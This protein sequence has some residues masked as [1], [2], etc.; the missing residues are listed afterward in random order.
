MTHKLIAFAFGAAL[1]ASAAPHAAAQASL[2]AIGNTFDF[3]YGVSRDASTVVGLNLGTNAGFKWDAVNGYVAIGGAPIQIRVDGDGSRI[4]GSATFSGFSTAAYWSGGAWTSIGGLGGSSGTDVSS[5]WGISD[6]GQTIVGLGWIN[7][8]SA[9]AF[10]WTQAGGIVDLGSSGASSRANAVSG[11]GVVVGG[12]DDN[13]TNGTRRPAYW[14][15]PGAPVL[16][17]QSPGAV[18]GA[19][20]D[21]KVLAGSLS[22]KVMR[23]T[24]QNGPYSLGALAAG[25]Q[26]SAADVDDQGTTLVGYSGPF[27][28]I[29]VRRAFIWRPGL[30]LVKL[31]DLLAAQGV[32]TTGW[33][34]W[35]AVGCS[36]DGNTIAGYASTPS[37]AKA[38]VAKLATG[39]GA[40]TT[41]C[42]AKVNSLGCTPVIASTGLASVTAGTGFTIGAADVLN[43]K[44]GLFFYGTTGQQAASFQ[45]GTLC[46]KAPIKRTT[47]QSSGG[48]AAPTADCS[49]TYGIDFNA[50]ITTGVDPN[51]VAGQ[52]VD[53]QFWSRDPGFSAPNNTG[54]TAG[55]H[56][57]IQP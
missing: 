23:W 28:P 49:G 22:Q 51:L 27:G 46:V 47:I 36:G 39:P 52:A 3:G 45:G 38:F 11:D 41:Y 42:T 32:D 53:G 21:G 35:S 54:L 7:A 4:S 13:P 8:G 20:F 40:G 48:S 17:S 5:A 26:A 1:L 24:Q 6:D 55:I 56:F 29:S 19:S 2:Q 9:H 16:I 37:G 31:Q 14:L 15:T 44:S 50:Y 25:D 43:N 57:V 33:T 34:L 30:G 12:W 10:R 18:E